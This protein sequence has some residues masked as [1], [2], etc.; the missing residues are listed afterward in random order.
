MGA[1]PS[2]NSCCPTAEGRTCLNFKVSAKQARK[3]QIQPSSLGER[4]TIPLASAAWATLQVAGE[5]PLLEGSSWGRAWG[6]AVLGSPRA[7]SLLTAGREA[8]HSW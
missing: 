1:H 4:S 8:A 5:E 2:R 7:R 3:C 6:R